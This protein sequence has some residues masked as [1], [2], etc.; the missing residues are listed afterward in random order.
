M[1]QFLIYALAALA[2]YR[3]QYAAPNAV[4]ILIIWRREGRAGRERSR[5]LRRDPPSP[6]APPTPPP[7]PTT[8]AET[9]A[10]W[11]RSQGL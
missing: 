2:I 4:L 8:L 6:P 10:A 5:P 11:R 1:N 9:R 7:R 3:P